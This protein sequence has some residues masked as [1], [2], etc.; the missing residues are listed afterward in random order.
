MNRRCRPTRCRQWLLAS[1]RRLVIEIDRGALSRNKSEPCN[2]VPLLGHWSGSALAGFLWRRDVSAEGGPFV[3]PPP[4]MTPVT[5]GCPTARSSEPLVP[6]VDLTGMSASSVGGQVVAY[7]SDLVGSSTRYCGGCH[8]D[9]AQG[10]RHIAEECRRFIAGFDA[11]WLEPIMQD[12]DGPTASRCRLPASR[13]ASA[14]PAIRSVD[15][16]MHAQAWLSAGKPRGLRGRQRQ[17]GGST[18]ATGELHVH[19]PPS[20]RR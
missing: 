20:P 18:T 6:R 17:G 5:S 19:A 11:S 13:G 9:G 3:Q 1:S 7:T 12:G 2:H 15:F 14:R 10:N 8:V 4:T 16:V